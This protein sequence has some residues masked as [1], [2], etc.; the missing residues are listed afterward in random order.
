VKLNT[1]IRKGEF[2]GEI[3]SVNLQHI[4]RGSHKNI[5]FCDLFSA[6][7][8]NPVSVKVKLHEKFIF[9]RRRAFQ[10][11]ADLLAAV[12]VVVDRCIPE[13][14]QKIQTININL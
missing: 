5:L 7:K 13:F 8:K 4:K 11:A 2:T 6:N 9:K 1:L 14:G 10:I 12:A 3:R